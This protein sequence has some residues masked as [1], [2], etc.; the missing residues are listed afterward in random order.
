MELIDAERIRTIMLGKDQAKK[1]R[2]LTLLI[3][4]IN[5]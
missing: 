3:N 4:A 1:D 5:G 2:A